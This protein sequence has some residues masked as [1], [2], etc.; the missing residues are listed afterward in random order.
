MK[1]PLLSY[2]F[3]TL[4]IYSFSFGQN[5]SENQNAVE[6]KI[7][8]EQNE[9][10]LSLQPRVQNHSALNLEYNYLLLVKKTDKGNNLSVN[11]QSGKFTMGPNESK[12]LSSIIINQS[13][14]Q[15]IKAILYIRDEN[16]KKLITKDS[17]EIKSFNPT[18]QVEETTLL[19]EGLVVD[20]T[21]TRVG[22]DFY[23]EFF[24]IYNQSPKK[25]N[26]II[27]ISEMPYR[28]QTSIIQVKADQDLLYE[29]FSNPNEEFI[30]EQAAFSIQSINR[31][32]ISKESV[33]QEFNY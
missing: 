13:Q 21:K 33:K 4:L 17:I 15:I 14:N 10:M 11:R 16:E 32:A 25:H 5:E 24:S 29:F 1:T 3:F 23:D 7:E 19:I 28:G 12:I 20:E 26:F 2:L 31:Y 9:N 30:K 22:A 18:S 8:V 27:S 6:A